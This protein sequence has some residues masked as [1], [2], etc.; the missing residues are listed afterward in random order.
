MEF[1]GLYCWGVEEG[2]DERWSA[3]SSEW[4]ERVVQQHKESLYPRYKQL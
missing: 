3:W 1:I 2:R 4:D